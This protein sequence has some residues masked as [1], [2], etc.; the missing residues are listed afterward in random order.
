MAW[1]LPLPGKDLEAHLI[2]AAVELHRRCTAESFEKYSISL[3]DGVIL[4]FRGV[5]AALII[6]SFAALALPGDVFFLAAH[7]S[8][9]ERLVI[10]SHL[11]GFSRH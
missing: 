8:Q 1:V 11:F 9:I 10:A 2:F 7:Q 3:V 5:F 4:N 6:L